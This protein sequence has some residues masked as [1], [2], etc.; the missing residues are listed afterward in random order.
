MYLEI[1]LIY[2]KWE[3]WKTS[4]ILWYPETPIYAQCPDTQK[5]SNLHTI[6]L[7]FG[8]LTCVGV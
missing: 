1:R 7:H 3:M 2:L 4:A 8:N 5:S 6:L